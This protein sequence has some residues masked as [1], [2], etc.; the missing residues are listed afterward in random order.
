MTAI[1]T[2]LTVPVGVGLLVFALL[3]PAAVMCQRGR[4]EHRRPSLERLADPT[5]QPDLDRHERTLRRALT[6]H[7]DWLFPEDLHDVFEEG[8]R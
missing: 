1:E 6:D 4:R 2:F 3:G 5:F 7:A 8:D